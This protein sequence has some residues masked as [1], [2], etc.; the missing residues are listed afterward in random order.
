MPQQHTRTGKAHDRAGL[1]FT[2]RLVTV[3]G[4]IGAGRLV[5]SVGAFLQPQLSIIEKLATAFAVSIMVAAVLCTAIH[6][7][8]FLHGQQL[9]GKAFL[10]GKHQRALKPEKSR[11]VKSRGVK[12]A[13][14]RI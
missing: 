11:G 4:T 3:N 10:V 6:T 5:V 13:H 2:P 14:L 9:A 8:H 7:D 12:S 1:F